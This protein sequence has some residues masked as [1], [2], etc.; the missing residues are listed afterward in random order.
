MTP[1]PTYSKETDMPE[2]VRI[3]FNRD[4]LDQFY[5]VRGAKDGKQAWE[6]A[7]EKNSNVGSYPPEPDDE[8]D[9]IDADVIEIS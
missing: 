2:N 8:F 5:V 7:R 1:N 6:A 9:L 3:I 4:S